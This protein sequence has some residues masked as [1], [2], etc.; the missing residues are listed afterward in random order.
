[1]EFVMPM[2][3]KCSEFA[4]E[5]TIEFGLG[6]DGIDT[7]FIRQLEIDLTTLNELPLQ[8]EVQVYFMDGSYAVLDSMFTDQIVLL[9]AATVDAGGKLLQAMEETNTAAF[10]TEKLGNLDNTEYAMIQAR[11]LTSGGGDQFVKLYTHYSLD[12]ELA[13]YGKFRLNTREMN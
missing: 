9:E 7:S 6:E 13:I 12:F 4:L 8:M 11:L 1:M 5:D 10:S 3:L 2:D